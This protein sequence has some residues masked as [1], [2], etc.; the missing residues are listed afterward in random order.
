MFQTTERKLIMPKSSKQSKHS[1]SSVFSGQGV[2][3]PVTIKSIAKELGVSFST[4]SK[5]LNDNPNIKEE[6]RNAV[7]SKAKEMGY[8]PNSLA[9]SLRSNESLTIAVILNDIENPVLTHIFKR[10]S[11]EMAKFGYTTIIMDSYF[12]L[13]T[14]QKNISVILAQ[15][16]DFIIWE[17]SS[18]GLEN[19]KYFSAMTDR[20]I[21]LG[22]R[23]PVSGIH[24][25]SVDY[26]AGGYETAMNMLSCGHRDNLVLTVPLTAPN[27]SSYVDGIRSAYREFGLELSKDRILTTPYSTVAGGFTQI[28]RLWDMITGKFRIPFS[29]VMSFDDNMACGV[30]KAVRQFGLRVPEDVSITGFDDNPLIAFFNPALSTVHLPQ[31]EIAESCLN[32]IKARLRDNDTEIQGYYIRPHL[33]KRESVCDLRLSSPS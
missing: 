10:I 26:R 29:G 13:D 30:L 5:A 32:I 14:E 21:L 31:E 6:T 18:T 25:V 19:L 4:V 16:P 33:V 22:P 2:G 27:S 28:N 23:F 7:L 15:K 1:R 3:K 12:D 8:T 17:P 11:D 20:L 9:R 24:Q